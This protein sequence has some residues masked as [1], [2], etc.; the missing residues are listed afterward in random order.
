MEEDQIQGGFNER[1]TPE[2]RRQWIKDQLEI[3]RRPLAAL[4]RSVGLSSLDADL[5]A[6]GRL[7]SD[8]LAIK[9]CRAVHRSKP[10][11]WPWLYDRDGKIK[12]DYVVAEQT[13]QK[14]SE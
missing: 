13:E 6:Q 12:G 5:V 7:V 8:P 10:Q 1:D 9:I 2:E 14:R 3:T 11:L 4:G